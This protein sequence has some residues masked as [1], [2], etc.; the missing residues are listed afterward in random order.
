MCSL[1]L[2]EKSGDVKHSPVKQVPVGR[3]PCRFRLMKSRLSLILNFMTMGSVRVLERMYQ[4][5]FMNTFS[6]GF[7]LVLRRIWN[8]DDTV[9][10]VCG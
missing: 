9:T 2:Y 5:G 1:E 3:S 4:T 8:L 7:Y 10:S 6:V